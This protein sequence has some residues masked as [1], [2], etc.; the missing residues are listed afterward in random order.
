VHRIE[1][2]GT[3]H[4]TQDSHA[5]DEPAPAQWRELSYRDAITRHDEGFA[6]IEAAHAGEAGRGFAV[7]AAEIKKLAESTRTS[8]K[9]I[10]E[11]IKEVRRAVTTAEASSRRNAEHSAS[12]AGEA[13]RVRDTLGTMQTT[14]GDSADRIAQIARSSEVSPI[15]FAE[16][17][18]FLKGIGRISQLPNLEMNFHRGDS[19]HDHISG[20]PVV[21]LPDR[22]SR[23]ADEFKAI[24]KLGARLTRRRIRKRRRS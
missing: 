7:V 1:A 5:G 21:I 11:T 23:L 15:E 6:A 3:G 14:I 24:A 9:Q 20:V 16:R 17:Q 18:Q 12:V 22:S 4:D 8:T 13:A 10:S 2:R 19:L